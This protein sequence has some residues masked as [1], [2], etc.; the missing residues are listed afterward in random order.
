MR[1]DGDFSIVL[2]LVD[3]RELALFGASDAHL[4]RLLFAEF[5]E[6]AAEDSEAVAV[7]L[8]TGDGREVTRHDFRAPRPAVL[9]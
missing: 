3:G 2:H 5:V 4:A 1:D 6:R 7:S 9:Q 8:I